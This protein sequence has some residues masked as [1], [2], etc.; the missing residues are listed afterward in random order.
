MPE[1]RGRLALATGDAAAALVALEEAGQRALAIA[2]VNPMALMWR[3]Y[4]GLAAAP[5]QVAGTFRIR[6][7]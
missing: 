2:Y 3:R 4:A 1:P 7:G 6:P 5:P